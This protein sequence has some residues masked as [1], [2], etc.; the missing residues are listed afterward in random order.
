VWILES[1]PVL[2][3]YVQTWIPIVAGCGCRHILKLCRFLFPVLSIFG[4]CS[5]SQSMTKHDFILGREAYLGLYIGESTKF[6][7][8]WWWANQMH[9][10]KKKNLKLRAHPS[11]I[12]RSMK[13]KSTVAPWHPED[14]KSA[15]GPY[16]PCLP[17][18]ESIFLRKR[19][20][21]PETKCGSCYGCFWCVMGT[22]RHI[23]MHCVS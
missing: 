17:L 23:N 11:L 13:T 7:K 3:G 9:H 1:G 21:I 10:E 2:S 18:V 4:G 12:D 6:Q 16:F 15:I 20:M 8:Y 5:F 22:R 19:W 14:R